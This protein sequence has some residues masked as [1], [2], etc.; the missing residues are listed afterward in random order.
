MEYPMIC[1]NGPRPEPDGTYS[2]RTKYGLISVVI[3]E[4]GHNYF[5]MIVNSD[6]RQWTWM[7]EGLN[8]FLQFLAEQEWEHD[9]PSSRGEPRDIVRYMKGDGQVPIMTASDSAL[10][11]G[12]NAYSKPATALN[13]LRETVMGRELFDFA[14]RQYAQRWMFKRPE[15][16]DL[17]RTLEDASAVDL[18]W[19]WN[20]WFYTTKHVDLALEPVKR[21][22]IDTRDPEVE[23]A[24]RRLARSEEPRSLT[25][26]RNEA[27]ETRIDRFPELADFYNEYDDLDISQQELDDYAK[28]VEGLSE[29][30]RELLGTKL[31]FHVA[32]VRDVGGIPMPITL[33]F[34]YADESV[35][36]VRIPVAVWRRN[37]DSV[38]KL[39]VSEQELVRVVLDP[40]REIADA[41]LANNVWPPAIDEETIQLEP[42]REGGRR[43]R[44]GANPM[45]AAREAEE[46]KAKAEAEAKEPVEAGAGTSTPGPAGGG[47]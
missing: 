46:E 10:Q 40:H 39:V 7:D 21:Y 29:E 1:F 26:Q 43:G 33:A 37:P 25:E 42:S 35:E 30:D 5:P 4:V 11:L 13:V 44:G 32:S 16:A 22:R 23:K 20:G 2:A 28:L 34:H 6:E 24:R 19:F 45:R 12:P 8:T 41:D 9:Y 27:L 15:P 36:E 17:F 3:H 18:D 38:S 47:R 31:R 14:F